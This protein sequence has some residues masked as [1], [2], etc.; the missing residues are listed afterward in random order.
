MADRNLTAQEGTSNRSGYGNKQSVPLRESEYIGEIAPTAFPAF[1][2]QTFPV[3]PGQAGCFPWLS[4]IA[5]NFEKYEFESLV[6][7]YKREVSEFATNGQTGKVIMSF[8]SDAT[9]PAPTTKQLMEDTDPHVDDMPC[10][11]MRLTIPREILQKFN[12]SK[13]VRPGAQPANTDLKTYDLGNLFVAC[14]G[15]AANTVVGELHVEYALRLRIPI[16]EA[17]T[18]V[19]ATGTVAA[20]GGSIAAATPFGAAPVY[21]ASGLGISAAGSVVTLTG[22]TIGTEYSLAGSTVGTAVSACNSNAPTG[23]TLKTTS[24]NNFNAGATSGAFINTYTATAT[25]ATANFAVTATTVTATNL[26]VTALVPP[27]GF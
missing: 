19:A 9:A 13:Y 12:D 23:L 3:N 24:P 5:Q 20:A 21:T 11:N 4:R 8:L 16:L 18:A 1:S 26:I 10:K 6:F 17:A 22:L 27:P 15:T 14:Q 7:I 25:T 2:V